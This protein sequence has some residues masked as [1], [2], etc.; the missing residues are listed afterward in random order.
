MAAGEHD[1]AD[2]F[3]HLVGAT[4]ETGGVGKAVVGRSGG[5][6]A[7]HS[8]IV[9]V[10]NLGDVLLA[11]YEHGVVA[12]GDVEHLGLVLRAVAGKFDF[13]GD[14]GAEL[15]VNGMEVTGLCFTVYRGEEAS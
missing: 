15:V 9:G 11:D 10:K 12:D 3:A 2:S 14:A 13:A 8:L 1:I 6:E 4:G 5:V 7:Q